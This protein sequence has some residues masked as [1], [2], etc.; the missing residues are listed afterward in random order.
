MNAH[1]LLLGKRSNGG[2][3]VKMQAQ[4]LLAVLWPSVRFEPRDQLLHHVERP[5]RCVGVPRDDDEEGANVACRFAHERL[6]R[7]VT[8]L[9]ASQTNDLIGNRS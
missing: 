5:L 3:D 8:P 2:N 9:P 4:L 7:D 6:R 1:Q